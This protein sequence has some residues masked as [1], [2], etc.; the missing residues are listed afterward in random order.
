MQR[1]HLLSSLRWK[2]RAYSLREVEAKFESWRSMRNVWKRHRS[3]SA[4]W[5]NKRLGSEQI[6]ASGVWRE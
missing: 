1:F 3:M 5:N 4:L 6:R 2:R